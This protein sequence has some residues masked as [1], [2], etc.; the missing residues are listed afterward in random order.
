MIRINYPATRPQ[1]KQS[2]GKELIFCIIR[3]KWIIITPEEWVRQNLL[4]YLTEVLQYPASL[5]AVEKQLMLGELKKRFDVVVYKNDVPF[6]LIECKEMNVPITQKTLDQLLRY[7]INLQA[8]YFIITNGTD[9]YGFERDG[10]AM[11]ALNAFP[12]Y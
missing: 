11:Q 3:K 10:V 12:A 1:I 6:M 7:N 2:N 5:I 9:C 8:N 4:M